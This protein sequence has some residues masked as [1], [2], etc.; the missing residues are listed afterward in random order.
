[1]KRNMRF[2]PAALLAVALA[3]SLF[4]L[5]RKLFCGSST[6]EWDLCRR[7]SGTAGPISDSGAAQSKLDKSQFKDV[8]VSVDNGIATLS[9]TVSLAEYKADAE[10]RV[11]KSK[12]VSAVRNMIEVEGPIRS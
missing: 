4:S 8:K 2:S 5:P 6:S 1:M 12:G 9:G 11:L 7:R 3:G 10:K